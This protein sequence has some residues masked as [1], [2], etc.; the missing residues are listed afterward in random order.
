MTTKILTL[1]EADDPV[2]RKK[3]KK[4]ALDAKGQADVR[5]LIEGLTELLFSNDGAAGIAAPQVG[6]SKRCFVMNTMA[7]DLMVVINPSIVRHGRDEVDAVESCLSLPDVWKK[8]TRWRVIDVEFMTD[9]G[10]VVRRTLKGFPARVFQH[11]Y[12]HIQGKLI[13]D[14]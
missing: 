3:A 6:V 14:Y 10:R 12:D 7:T 9:T 4:V 8:V 2:L 5:E 13:S 11:E 1:V